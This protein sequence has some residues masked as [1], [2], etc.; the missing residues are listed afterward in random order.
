MIKS[1]KFISKENGKQAETVIETLEGISIEF[2]WSVTG[3]I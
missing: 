2:L 1:Y 3:G